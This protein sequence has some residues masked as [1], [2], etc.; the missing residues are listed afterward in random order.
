MKSLF[1][2]HKKYIFIFVTIAFVMSFILTFDPNT[3]FKEGHDRKILSSLIMT[4]RENP[5]NVRYQVFKVKSGS[6]IIVET[7]S[8]EQDGS[9]KLLSQIDTHGKY[10]GYF[11]LGGNATN[12]AYLEATDTSFPQ[13][14]APSFDKNLIA[15]LN[16][17]RYD[18]LSKSFTL[19]SNIPSTLD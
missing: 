11:L 16:V 4:P 9:Y 8:I 6:T 14:I 15:Y 3:F 5:G 10:D 12:L 2:Q 18:P 1:A 7:Y 13:I 19:L 17:I